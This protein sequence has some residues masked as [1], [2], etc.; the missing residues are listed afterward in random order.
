MH[1]VQ[2]SFTWD[3]RQR[4][5]AW[6]CT[7]SEKTMP[8]SMTRVDARGGYVRC[9]TGVSAS[10]T[11][12]DATPSRSHASMAGVTPS[13]LGSGWARRAAANCRTCL[14]FVNVLRW[15]CFSKDEPRWCCQH[16][17]EALFSRLTSGKQWLNNSVLTIWHVT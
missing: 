7:Q 4:A 1:A 10:R 13:P 8:A 12:L 6:Q 2:I 15:S 9:K 14:S 3:Y 11:S 16:E 17:S 5:S